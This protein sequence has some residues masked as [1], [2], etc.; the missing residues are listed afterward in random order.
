MIRLT[1][2][3]HEMHSADI[4]AENTEQLKA[5]FPEAYPAGKVELT[6]RKQLLGGAVEE[7]EEIFADEIEKNAVIKV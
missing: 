4:V 2:T 5:L 3:D 1:A 6:L 7:R